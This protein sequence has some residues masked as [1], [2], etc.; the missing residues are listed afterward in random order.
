MVFITRSDNGLGGD[1]QEL[2]VYV[3]TQRS[4]FKKVFYRQVLHGRRTVRTFSAFIFST[5]RLL[6]AYA[7]VV[8][9]VLFVAG[10]VCKAV[11]NLA[12]FLA[13]IETTFADPMKISSER[14]YCARQID[15]VGDCRQKDIV[16]G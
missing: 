16:S 1:L 10:R 3:F 12:R 4:D 2:V 15:G 13:F 6:M 14:I 11:F 5:I 7:E 9:S 8:C